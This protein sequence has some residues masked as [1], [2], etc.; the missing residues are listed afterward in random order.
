MTYLHCFCSTFLANMK[1]WLYSGQ[2]ESFSCGYCVLLYS[3]LIYYNDSLNPNKLS[4]VIF[5]PNMFEII[6]KYRKQ[7]IKLE[8]NS[9]TLT[10]IQIQ[11]QYD[12]FID[13]FQNN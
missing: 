2:N 8:E 11:S 4:N 10:K 9:L 3:F 5:D 12:S 7:F 1:D 13:D 6:Y